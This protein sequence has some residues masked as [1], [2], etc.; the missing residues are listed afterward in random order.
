MLK[1]PSTVSL[2]SKEAILKRAD[3]I[4]EL[5]MFVIANGKGK[6]F[7]SFFISISHQMLSLLC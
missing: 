7:T 1:I 3:F 5:F 4:C 2:V 6:M